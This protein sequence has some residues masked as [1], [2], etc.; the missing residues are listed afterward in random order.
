MTGPTQLLTGVFELEEWRIDGTPFV[1]PQVAGRFIVLDG[2]VTT[3]LHRRTAVGS[4]TS[5]ILAGTFRLADGRFEYAY[6][7]AAIFTRT[8]DGVHWSRDPPWVGPRRFSVHSSGDAL[9]LRAEDGKSSFAFRRSEMT[10]SEDG[11]VLRVW[12]RVNPPS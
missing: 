10:Y 5:A 8:P 1:P 11:R 3:V 12:R 2:T 6:Q 9:D 4:E 7:D